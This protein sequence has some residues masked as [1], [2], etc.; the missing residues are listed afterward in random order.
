VVKRAV[1]VLAR[2]VEAVRDVEPCDARCDAEV[3]HVTPTR[4]AKASP[5]AFTNQYDCYRLT[6]THAY[7]LKKVHA[8]GV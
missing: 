2:D 4:R 8:W 3:E 7:L 6:T 5:G 1:R